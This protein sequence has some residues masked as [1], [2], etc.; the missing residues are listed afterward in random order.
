MVSTRDAPRQASANVSIFVKF[1]MY[2][3]SYLSVSSSLD[4]GQALPYL[5]SAAPTECG[6]IKSPRCG[7]TRPPE[8]G[9]N[10]FNFRS[11]TAQSIPHSLRSLCCWGGLRAVHDG[12]LYS[13]AQSKGMRLNRCGLARNKNCVQ[14]FAHGVPAHRLGIY[15]AAQLGSIWCAALGMWNVRGVSKYV[16]GRARERNMLHSDYVASMLWRSMDTHLKC[17]AL[18]SC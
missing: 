8:G 14:Y 12:S 11:Q 5:D 4:L 1:R 18:E 7:G 13:V 17:L 6:I 3:A 9:W 15:G 16:A 10:V 2:T